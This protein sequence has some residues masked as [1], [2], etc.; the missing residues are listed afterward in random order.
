MYYKLLH[1]GAATVAHADEV[2]AFGQGALRYAERGGYM[3]RLQHR[4]ALHIALC[5]SLTAHRQRHEQPQC[6]AYYPIHEDKGADN[7]LGQN[8]NAAPAMAWMPCEGYP[9]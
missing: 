1:C 7:L 3:R 8:L 4:A 2:D 6:Y 5:R 9:V